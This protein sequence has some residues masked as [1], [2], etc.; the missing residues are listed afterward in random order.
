[1]IQLS[2]SKKKSTKENKIRAKTSREITFGFI[3]SFLN[4]NTISAKRQK[5][6]HQGLQSKI[7]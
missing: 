6:L 4:L 7:I 1:V 3:S 2:A 5:S